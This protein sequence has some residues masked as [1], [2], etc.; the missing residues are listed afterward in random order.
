M[1]CKLEPGPWLLPV[2]FGEDFVV[3][4][5]HSV[6]PPLAVFKE[7]LVMLKGKSPAMLGRNFVAVMRGTARTPKRREVSRTLPRGSLAYEAVQHTRLSVEVA[8]S[9]ALAYRRT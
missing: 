3:L 5:P 8:S 6:M 4:I 7:D 2:V 9:L 1:A